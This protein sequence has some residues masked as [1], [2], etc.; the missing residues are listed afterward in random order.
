V[1]FHFNSY[2]VCVQNN[3]ITRF[4]LLHYSNGFLHAPHGTS[5]IEA[6]L[7]LEIQLNGC[8]DGTFPLHYVN[9]GGRDQRLWWL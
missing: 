1:I 9:D 6:E 5:F 8:F 3:L 2:T 7:Q 4:P